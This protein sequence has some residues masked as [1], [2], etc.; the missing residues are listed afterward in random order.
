MKVKPNEIS[1]AHRSDKPRDRGRSL[2]LRS[3]HRKKRNEMLI[4]EKKKLKVK[5]R[6]VYINE[7]LRSLRATMMSLVKEQK[8]KKYIYH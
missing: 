5:Q 3:C 4:K 1:V 2:I 7:D 6:K 8:T